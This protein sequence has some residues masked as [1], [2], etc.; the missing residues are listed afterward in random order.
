MHT[1]TRTDRLVNRR[2]Q[3]QSG[4]PKRGNSESSGGK[5]VRARTGPFHLN[6][7]DYVRLR[8]RRPDTQMESDLRV[9]MKIN[10]NLLVV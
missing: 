8:R 4:R 3:M 10:I 6:W 9:N 2:K 7:P 5:T 1:H